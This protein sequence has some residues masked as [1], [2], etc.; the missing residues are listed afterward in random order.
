MAR[1]AATSSAQMINVTR[2]GKVIAVKSGGM[3]NRKLIGLSPPP[4]RAARKAIAAMPIAFQTTSIGS[5]S[6]PP[7]VL[8]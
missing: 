7:P 8:A 4:S 5:R 1:K 3:T 2:N 6:R